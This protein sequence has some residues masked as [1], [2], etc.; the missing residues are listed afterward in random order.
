MFLFLASG[1][2]DTER[3]AHGNGELETFVKFYWLLP[4][5]VF[6]LLSQR[7]L[8]SVTPL[9]TEVEKAVRPVS[10]G[11]IKLMNQ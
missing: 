7:K 9:V 2:A 4:E 11:E 1:V 5:V 3:Q 6:Q 8:Q 10:D